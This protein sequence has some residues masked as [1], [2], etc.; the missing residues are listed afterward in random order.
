MEATIHG[1]PNKQKNKST[2][3]TY[4]WRT[5]TWREIHTEETCTRRDVRKEELIQG[6]EIH[7]EEQAN[8]KIYICRGGIGVEGT[9]IRWDIHTKG[10]YTEGRRNAHEGS[11]T[12]RNIHT[13]GRTWRRH[14]YGGGCRWR[15]IHKEGHTNRETYTQSG[16]IHCT[17]C[18]DVLNRSMDGPS[19]R[20]AGPVG[21]TKNQAYG[22][23]LSRFQSWS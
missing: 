13:E 20:W 17:D 19:T 14:T 5:Y 10:T 22:P 9:Q 16:H 23:G 21:L 12:R 2:G 15:D 18:V 6:G 3:A 1:G 11:Y 7:I 8:K 4:D